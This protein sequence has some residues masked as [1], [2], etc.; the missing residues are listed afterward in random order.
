M[1]HFL[2]S[3]TAAHTAD[4]CLHF[5]LAHKSAQFGSGNVRSASSTICF[6]WQ[7]LPF[8][9]DN[10]NYYPTCYKVIKLFW[11]FYRIVGSYQFDP[12]SMNYCTCSHFSPLH[13]HMARW[14]LMTLN[15]ILSSVTHSDVTRVAIN[16]QYLH[17]IHLFPKQIL[18]KTQHHA[19]SSDTLM[20]LSIILSSFML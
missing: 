9:W 13:S 8:H 1:L 18:L 16:Q 6:K 3:H 19:Q 12:V 15:I 17:T 7:L 14:T 2:K 5:L 11:L 10:L 4:L 20:T